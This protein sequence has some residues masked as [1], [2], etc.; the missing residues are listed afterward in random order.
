MLWDSDAEALETTLDSKNTQTISHIQLL[1]MTL[2]I[3]SNN[4]E[5][6]HFLFLTYVRRKNR[7][8]EFLTENFTD[9]LIYQMI[10]FYKN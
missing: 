3:F 4:M 6:K 10:K 2:N 8:E 7:T 5:R 1:H 9:E